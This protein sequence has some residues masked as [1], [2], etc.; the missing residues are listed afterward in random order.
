ML[1][2]IPAGLKALGKTSEEALRK[3]FSKT[4]WKG[5]GQFNVCI[6]YSWADLEKF[7]KIAVT[8]VVISSYQS[9]ILFFDE[10]K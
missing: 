10:D 9:Y 5:K 4:L 2:P 8:H 1:A 6:G 7:R 3:L